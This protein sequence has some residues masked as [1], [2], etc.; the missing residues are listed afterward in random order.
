M[1]F[2]PERNWKRSLQ[3][4]ADL[5]TRQMGRLIIDS[6]EIAEAIQELDGVIRL[7]TSDGQ[8]HLPYSRAYQRVYNG[9]DVQR[10]EK[11]ALGIRTANSFVEETDMQIKRSKIFVKSP[12]EV[13][14]RVLLAGNPV[15]TQEMEI[16]R[17]LL[18][19]GTVDD[20][21]ITQFYVGTFATKRAAEHATEM[22]MESLAHAKLGIFQ[23]YPLDNN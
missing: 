11:R 1:D 8:F 16:T 21:R 14:A 6:E 13:L 23:S 5:R 4:T 10:A 3:P 17:E 2:H 15:I 7:S 22:V 9:V 18:H 19:D 12:K 20:R